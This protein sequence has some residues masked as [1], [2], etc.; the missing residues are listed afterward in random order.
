MTAALEVTNLVK[1]FGGLTATNDL[2]FAL[3]PGES[4]GLIGP[5]GAGKTTV[6]SQIM[7][8]LRQ[9]SGSIK[10]FGTDIGGLSM[11]ERIRRGVSRTYQVP[12]PFA[13]L[14]VL[15]NI[16]VGFMPNSVWGMVVGRPNVEQESDL[17]HEVGFNAADLEKP[18]SDLSMGDLRKLELA[19]TLAT[20]AKLLLLDEVFAGLTVGEITQISALIQ[21]LRSQGIT[22]LMVSHDLPAL[23]PLVDRVIAIERGSMIAKGSFAEVIANE[24]V[25]AS[26]LGVSA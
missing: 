17:A 10:L 4:V 11:P 6:F 7:G 14:S 16:R 26:Y 9:T 1:T 25:R 21:K 19:R 13:D 23:D 8:E 12:R 24:E 22:M 2:S 18:A 3:E 5:N 15:E 20:G